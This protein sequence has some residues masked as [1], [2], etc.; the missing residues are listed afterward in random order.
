[1][2]KKLA[3]LLVLALTLGMFTFASASSTSYSVT[4][5]TPLYNASSGQMTNINLAANALNGRYISARQQFS[6][7]DIVGPRTAEAG[8][9]NGVN[10]RGVSVRGGGVAQVAATVMLA[11][12]QISNVKFTELHVYGDKYTQGYVAS[13]DDA[14]LTDYPSGKDFRFINNYDDMKIEVW[15][16]R[17][18]LYCTITV[19]AGTGSGTTQ[20][21]STN[22]GTLIGYASTPVS[23]TTTLKN[24]IRL[25][26]E[27]VNGSQLGY[28]STFSFNAIVGP[29]NN[30]RG[31]GSA[32][33]GR[34]V[35]ITGGGVAQVASTIY[36]AIKDLNCI[37]VT[38][39]RTYGDDYNQ[40]Y[41]TDP[42]DAVVTDYNGN[43]DFCFRYNGYGTLTVVMYLN[44]SSTRLT[45]EI[46]ERSS[47]SW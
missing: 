20:P 3:L 5:S 8:Y 11:A 26:S 41:V 21:P 18:Y 31:Y 6:F 32:I 47:W 4:A 39:L 35:H 36:L 45:C 30:A 46:Y 14:V 34:G 28:Y 9:R 19:Y 23:G 22:Y 1:M 10:G 38:T 24:N 44:S 33:N 2:N 37:K 17:S 13:G 12:K 40:R 29:R 7:N 15:V 16:S 27:S 43:V 42:E 25:A